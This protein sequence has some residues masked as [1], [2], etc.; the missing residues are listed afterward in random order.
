[1]RAER[2]GW[3]RKDSGGM[4]PFQIAV[5]SNEHAWGRWQD[6]TDSP[7][8][9]VPDWPARR[10]YQWSSPATLRHDLLAAVQEINAR[11]AHKSDHFDDI[12]QWVLNDL[13][14]LAPDHPRTP[15]AMA[16]ATVWWKYRPTNS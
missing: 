5:C 6:E 4:S 8:D 12:V 13:P 16:M 3:M 15:D 7:W 10:A 11:P 2:S 1:M 14:S 9:E